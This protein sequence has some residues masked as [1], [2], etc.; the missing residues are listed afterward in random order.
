M[1]S[2]ACHRRGAVFLGKPIIFS[3]LAFG[4]GEL[5]VDSQH[6]AD[7]CCFLISVS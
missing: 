2:L 4:F 5:S 3:M 6:A 7:I 1:L